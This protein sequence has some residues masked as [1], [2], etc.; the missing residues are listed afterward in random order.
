MSEGIDEQISALKYELEKALRIQK[1]IEQNYERKKKLDLLENVEEA[2]FR[3]DLDKMKRDVASLN[4][5]LASLESQKAR[6]KAINN[7]Y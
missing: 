1:N 3:S 2:E 5:Q 4:R 7:E 6:K